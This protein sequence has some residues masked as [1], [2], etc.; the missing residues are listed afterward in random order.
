MHTEPLAL[1]ARHDST[2]W[3]SI[4]AVHKFL[5]HLQS[6]LHLALLFETYPFRVTS[7]RHT[8]TLMISS[9]QMHTTRPDRFQCQKVDDTLTRISTPIHIVTKK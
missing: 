5:V 1:S 8:P 4:K 9:Q 2:Q 7:R 3:Q 6:I